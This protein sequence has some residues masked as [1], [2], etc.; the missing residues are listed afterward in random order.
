MAG[1]ERLAEDE[2]NQDTPQLDVAAQ[3]GSGGLFAGLFGPRV[4][5]EDAEADAPADDTVAVLEDD[6]AAPP[7]DEAGDAV[8]E[9][10]VAPAPRKQTGG[11]F[12]ALFGNSSKPVTARPAEAEVVPAS[13]IVPESSTELAAKSDVPFGTRLPYGQVAK[14]C[15]VPDQKL[16]KRMAQYPERQPLYRLYDSDPGNTDPHAF[17]LTGFADG[18]AR[19][20]TAALAVFG[21]VSMHEQLRYGLPAEVQPYSDTDKAYEKLKR[22]VCNKPRRKPCGSKIGLLEGDTVF[23]SIY[24]RFDSNSHWSNLLIHR[25]TLLAQDRKKGGEG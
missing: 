6:L 15:G 2:I 7:S 12:G 21:S 20:F 10:T 17:Y 24:E 3:P 19:Q 14:I 8:V 4:A 23:L 5:P 9:V 1:I 13:L 25:G 16:G 22:K 11:F 18:C